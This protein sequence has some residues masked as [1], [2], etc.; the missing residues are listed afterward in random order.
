MQA[1]AGRSAA[2]G[3]EIRM[4]RLPAISTGFGSRLSAVLWVLWVHLGRST[5]F[6][7][8]HG[9]HLGER[10]GVFAPPPARRPKPLDWISCCVVVIREHAH[11]T[12][13]D[14]KAS[15]LPVGEV[16]VTAGATLHGATHTTSSD[17]DM[18][19]ASSHVHTY[20]TRTYP[21]ALKYSCSSR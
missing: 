15:V 8:P 10:G 18:V 19:G 6:F 1:R 11:E 4:R 3:H 14:T 5:V 20:D 7:C 2:C 21:S 9:P 12:S 17:S 16:V 13:T